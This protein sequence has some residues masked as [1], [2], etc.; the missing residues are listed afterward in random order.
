MAN[1]LEIELRFRGNLSDLRFEEESGTETINPHMMTIVRFDDG[2]EKQI[3]DEAHTVGIEVEA[4][5]GVRVQ[6]GELCKRLSA[7]DVEHL[8]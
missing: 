1:P 3:M 8:F 4:H 5:K 6:M 2:T 7:G